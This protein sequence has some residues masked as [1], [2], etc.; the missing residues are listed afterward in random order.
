MKYM[1][2]KVVPGRYGHYI[3]TRKSWGVFDEI[4]KLIFTAKT[5]T[6]CENYAKEI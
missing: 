4:G 2:K 5:K 1:I 3:V 6:E